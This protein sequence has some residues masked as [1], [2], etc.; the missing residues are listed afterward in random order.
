MKKDIVGI[1]ADKEERRRRRRKR[2]RSSF[3][4]LFKKTFGEDK[5]LAPYS[6]SLLLLH[7]KRRNPKEVRRRN[8]KEVVTLK[9]PIIAIHLLWQTNSPI[10]PTPFFWVPYPTST[11]I[12]LLLLLLLLSHTW[13]FP[14]L[15]HVVML[16]RRCAM[17]SA[18][19]A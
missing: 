11:Q 4:S 10:I 8:P 18:W 5:I 19:C 14:I 17:A 12:P 9:R 6:P 3:F 1:Q 13:G 7:P 15:A 16:G 2:K